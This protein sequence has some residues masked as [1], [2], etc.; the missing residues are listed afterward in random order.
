LSTLIKEDDEFLYLERY[1]HDDLDSFS[2]WEM[3]ETHKLK[4]PQYIQES[5]HYAYMEI[6]ATYR[7]RKSDG[8]VFYDSYE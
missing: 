2:G 3:D 6:K 7:I 1:L 4:Y 5:E 8:Q